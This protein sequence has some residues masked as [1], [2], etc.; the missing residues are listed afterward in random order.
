MKILYETWKNLIQSMPDVPPETGG[1][2]GGKGNIILIYQLDNG[3]SDSNGYDYY[4]PDIKM[5]NTTIA[6]WY[7]NGFEFYG[8]FH[9]HFPGGYTLS[10]GDRKYIH[11]IMYSMPLEIGS[12]YFPVIFP[13]EDIIVYRA[14]RCNNEVNI[15]C[16]KTEIL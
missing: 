11:T 3:S 12:L 1:I 16:E 10:Y 9:S 4:A 13:K 7:K 15:V 6:N 2:I 5:L 14:E 8:I